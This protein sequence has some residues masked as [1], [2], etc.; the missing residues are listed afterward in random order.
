[1]ERF[2]DLTIICTFLVLAINHWIM[3]ENIRK[4]AKDILEKEQQQ[5]ILNHRRLLTI[6]LESSRYLGILLSMSA[7]AGVII[8]VGILIIG[9]L[10]ALE[11]NSQIKEKLVKVALYGLVLLGITG[12]IYLI[13]PLLIYFY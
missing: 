1:M 4:E 10:I 5:K 8:G 12:L 6:L 7:L 3:L 2:R 9:L 11:I 13:I